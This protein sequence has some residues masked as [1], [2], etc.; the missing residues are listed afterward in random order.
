M[1]QWLEELC[2]LQQC[3]EPSV[4]VTVAGTRGSTPREA[5]AKMVVSS[6]Q[7]TGTI[8]GGHLEYRCTREAAEWLCGAHNA[9]AG[10]SLVRRITLGTE[11]GQCCGG[12]V[13]VLFEHIDAAQA[14]W[15]GHLR[16]LADEGTEATMVT[17]RISQTGVSK[18][19]VTA[20]SARFFGQ[21]F[22]LSGPAM[23]AAR[24]V[25]RSTAA[26]V[27]TDGDTSMLLEPVG[28][29]TLCIYLFGAGHVGSA[30]AGILSTLASHI[31]LVD[32]RRALIDQ[33]WPGGVT[34]V[35][36]ADPARI[37]GSAPSA[38]HFL[39]MT[40]DHAL[41]L[42]IC[43][44]VLQRDDFASCGL[45]GSISKRRRFE[46]RLRAVGISATQL[47]RLTCPVGIDSIRGKRPAE[48][49][50]A[51]AAQLITLHESGRQA[52]QLSSTQREYGNLSR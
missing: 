25:L 16:E 37:V 24:R 43:A 52:E 50:V 26:Q 51:V 42:E 44:A 14:P 20:E 6:T 4:L 11:C 40:H 5:G 21:E 1:S 23:A 39:V 34:P 31:V 2:R 49:A 19:V 3:G 48:I 9:A 30:C 15:L 38:T 45:I 47:N 29:A 13:D 7:T 32:S 18:C 36:T 8:G 35:A 27:V 41:D 12:V 10:S 46:K 28:P 17:P 33:R 22:F